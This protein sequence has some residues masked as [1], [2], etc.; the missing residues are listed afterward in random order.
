MNEK[1]FTTENF[2]KLRKTCENI[3]SLSDENIDGS[4]MMCQLELLGEKIKEFSNNPI[5]KNSGC[6]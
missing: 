5:I 2:N 1:T 6:I 3:I 4:L